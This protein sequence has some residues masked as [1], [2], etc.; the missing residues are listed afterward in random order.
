MNRSDY[1]IVV[2]G[3]GIGG[4]AF[5][6]LMA[7]LQNRR[8]LVL[9]RHFKIGGFT[10]TFS[11]PGQYVWDVGVHYVG[12]MAPGSEGRS[13]FDLITRAGVEWNKMPS[14]FEKFVYPDFTFAVADDPGQYRQDLIDRFPAERRAIEQYFK[15]LAAVGQ[16]LSAYMMAR[17]APAF[18]SLPARLLNLG[19]QSMALSTTR[20]Y[21]DRNFRDPRLKAVLASQWGDYGLPPSQSAFAIHALIVT[22]YMN[23]AYYPAGSAARIAESIVPIVE[24]HGGACRVNHEVTEILV[25]DRRAIGVRAAVK[26]G[27]RTETAEFY[28][29][30]VVSDAGA[31]TTFC[32]LL[33]SPVN[34]PFRQELDSLPH[35]HGMV[36]VY[37]GLKNDGRALGFRGENHWIYDGYDLDALFQRR[38]EL[39]QGKPTGCYLSFPSLKDPQAR[40]HTAEIIAMLDYGTVSPWR[41]Q[42]W[43]KR[44]QDYQSLKDQIAHTLIDFVDAHYP[45]FRDL[46]ACCEV[47]TPLTGEFFTGHARGSPYGIPAT[48][49]RFRKAWLRPQTPIRNLYLTGADV[50]SLGVMGAMMGGVATAIQLMGSAGYPRI[51]AEARK[52]QMRFTD[53]S[54]ASP[55]IPA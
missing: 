12:G 34:V 39:L 30:V 21:L 50:A 19:A 6:S 29:P 3:S 32:K 37:L 15:D 25:R 23:G 24:A 14:P 52:F 4:L 11:R 49:E 9:E 22:H 42:P 7:Q 27:A 47:S 26:K 13:F 35:G 46:V 8:V 43:R 5:A 55:P 20:E 54:A 16:W 1:D 33:P 38:N 36:T 28:A 48:P 31:R 44:D 17:M 18:I 51:V 40:N 10:H 45:G 53:G 2:I 41:D